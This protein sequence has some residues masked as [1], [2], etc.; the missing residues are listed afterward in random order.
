[1]YDTIIIG[2]G[3]I[4]SYLAEKLAH[5]GYKTLVLDKK[6]DV[7]DDVCCTGIVGKECLDLLAIDDDLILR[8]VNSARFVAPSGKSIRLW[9]NDNVAF[10]LDRPAL[11]RALADRAKKAGVDYQLE[12]LVTNIQ[13]D[14]QAVRVQVSVEQKSISHLAQT[15]IIATGLDSRLPQKLGLGNIVE[16]IIGAQAEVQMKG[17]DEV[18]V[19][20]DHELAPGGFAWLVP[21]CNGKGLAGLMTRQQPKKQ[22]RALLYQLKN[23][24]KIISDEISAGY[25]VIPLKPLPRSYSNRVL[26]VGEAAGQVKPTTGGSIY[27]GLLCADIAIDTLRAASATSDFSAL[28][29]ASYQKQWKTMLKREL[30]IGYLAHRLFRVMGN[31]QI[32]MLLTIMNNCDIQK[33]I[34]ESNDFSFDYHSKL[35]LKVMKH[36]TLSLPVQWSRGL[37]R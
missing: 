26:V 23:K 10:A 3:P 15:T 20:L 27:Y 37:S 18:E 16:S 7:G 12:S 24:D 21:T 8:Q 34:S 1:M 25:G 2:A 4:G 32:E 28:K 13:I 22:L 6:S 19:Y 30:L 9:R 14:S 31:R 35:I 11:N 5:H 33:L 36:L 17:M 29:L